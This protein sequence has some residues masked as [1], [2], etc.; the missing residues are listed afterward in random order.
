MCPS[1][2]RVSTMGGPTGRFMCR[3]AT[4]MPKRP[5][6]I[7]PAAPP[8]EERA[9]FTADRQSESGGERAGAELAGGVGG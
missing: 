4:S 8:E 9:G 7:T 3:L 1:S 2:P 6:R 5:R